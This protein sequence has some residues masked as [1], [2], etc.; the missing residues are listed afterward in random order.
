M[1]EISKLPGFDIENVNILIIDC[2]KA[3]PEIG[4]LMFFLD[5]D[6]LMPFDVLF[7]ENLRKTLRNHN[8]EFLSKVFC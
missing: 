4:F 5:F 7:S 1:T 8:V 3:R 6:I 2:K